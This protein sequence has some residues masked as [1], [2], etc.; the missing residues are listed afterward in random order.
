MFDSY[1]KK[2]L[3]LTVTIYWIFQASDKFAMKLW[4]LIEQI[5]SADK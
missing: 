3:N 1:F 5:N 4:I 2:R